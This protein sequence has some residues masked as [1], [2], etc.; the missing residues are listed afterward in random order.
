MT[1]RILYYILNDSTH[2]Y[3]YIRLFSPHALLGNHIS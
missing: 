1:L 3:I 2:I